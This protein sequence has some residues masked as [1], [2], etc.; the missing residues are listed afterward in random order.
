MRLGALI[1]TTGLRDNA[2]AASLLSPTGSTTA[3]QRMIAAF[4]CCGVRQICLVTEKDNKKGHRQFA[5]DGVIFLRSKSNT[6]SAL[7]GALLGLSYMRDKFDRIFL[8]TGDQSLFLPETLQTLLGSDAD[9]VVPTYSQMNGCPVL[10]SSHAVILLLKAAPNSSIEQAVAS[11][12]AQ[13]IFLPVNDPGII[14]QGVNEAN[15]M[16]LVERQA[17]QLLRPATDIKLQIG[18]LYFDRKLA[19]LLRLID[20][21][22]SVRQ[23]SELMQISYSTAWGMLNDA[24]DILDDPLV[25]RKRGGPVGS[26]CELSEHGRRLLN[27][28]DRYCNAL[29]KKADALYQDMFRNILD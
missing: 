14:V 24:D 29:Q 1:V 16:E 10:L 6:T 13:K 28:Y 17:R 20:E 22:H 4:Q 8:V 3:G 7:E 26:G 9:I 15:R 2:G 18:N 5:Q 11:T 12:P 25:F 21:T 23:A 19:S 27:A